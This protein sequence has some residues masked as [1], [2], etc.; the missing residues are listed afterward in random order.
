MA[1]NNYEEIF[2]K[3]L[4]YFINDYKNQE[5]I[6]ITEADIQFYLMSLCREL[7]KRENISLDIHANYEISKESGF[8]GKK[9][10]IVL[11]KC[12][13]VEI[14]FEA[15]YQGVSK[16]VVLA[17]EAANDIKRLHELKD[18]GMPYCH[19]IFLDEDG[20][21]VRNFQKYVEEKIEWIPIGGEKNAHLCTLLEL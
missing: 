2:A 5:Y 16:P 8:K 9:I 21:H 15:N 1:I 20:T 7:L 17:Y 11:G 14:K 4:N 19:F 3:A 13:A 18:A 10:D 6:P 12:V